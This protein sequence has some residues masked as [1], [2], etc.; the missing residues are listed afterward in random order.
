MKENKLTITINKP[1]EE[2]FLYTVNPENTAGWIDFIESEVIDTESPGLRTIYTNTSN[3]GDVGTYK[4]T[5]FEENKLFELSSTDGNFY[6][7][8]IYRPLSENST[9]LGYLEWV[10]EGEIT[11]PFEQLHL[12]KLK[13]ILEDA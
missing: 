1:V 7:R 11:E 3:Q 4:V 2:V 12:E 13:Q 5:A 9:E 6:V 10:D 8:Y